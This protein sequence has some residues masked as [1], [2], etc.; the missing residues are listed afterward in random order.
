MQSTKSEPKSHTGFKYTI[1]DYL[2]KIPKGEYSDQLDLLL[3][4]L[5]ISKPSFYRITSIPKGSSSSATSDQLL[6]IAEFFDCQ[7]D[8]LINKS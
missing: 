2:E 7:I 1:R 8:D 5:D 3:Q 6:V 4:K